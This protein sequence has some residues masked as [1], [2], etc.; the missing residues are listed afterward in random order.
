ML[1]IIILGLFIFVFYI[2][3]SQTNTTDSVVKSVLTTPSHIDNSKRPSMQPNDKI[4]Q[5]HRIDKVYRPETNVENKKNENQDCEEPVSTETSVALNHEKTS[6]ERIAQYKKMIIELKDEK[7]KLELKGENTSEIDRKI[8]KLQTLILRLSSDNKNISDKNSSFALNEHLANDKND[9][10]ITI[11]KSTKADPCASI[12]AM[13]LGVTYTG[14]LAASGSDWSTYTDCSYTESGDEGVYSFTPSSTGNYTFSGTATSGDPDFFLMSSCGNTGTNITGSCWDYGDRTVSLVAGTTYYLVVDN[15]SSSS[16]AEYSIIVNSAAAGPSNDDCTGAIT[17][18]VGA[19]CSFSSYTN[20]NATATSGVP[21]PGCAN[22]LGGD[23]WFKATVPASGHIILDMDDNVVTDAGMAIY[24]GTCGS[25]SL[26]ECDDDDSNNGL[27][28]MIDKSG[29]SSGTTI[30]IR[31][32]EYGNDNNGSFYICAY[33]PGIGACGSVTNIA[34]CGTSTTV[35]SGG[36]SGNWNNQECGSGTP[37]AE[38]I[39]SFTPTTTAAYYIVVTSA[40][41]Y[42]TYA[43]QTGTCQSTGWTCM[44]RPNAPG[45]FGPFNWTAGVTYYILVDDEDASSSTHTFYIKCPETPGTYYHPT[46]GLQGTYLGSCMVNTCTGTYTDDGGAANYS[47]NIN[48]IYRTFCPDATGKCIRAT[49]NSMDIEENGTSCY[50]YLIVRNGPTQGSP[51]LWAGCKTLASTNS[52]LG[53]FSNPFTA[54]NTSGCLTFQFYSDNTITRPGWNI[55]LS[56]VDCAASPTNNDCISATSICG[57]TNVNSASPGPGITSTCGGCNLSENY[58]NW[59]YF[60]ITNSGRL[61]LDIKPED[62]FE[63]YD[64]ALY[65]ASSC[66]NLGNPVRCTYAMTPQYCQPVSSGA[67][68]YISR[69]R[70]NTIDNTS[71]YYNDFY[72]NYTT[73]I[74]STVTAG[75]A[76]NLQVTVA[77][78]SMYVVAWF[79][80]NKN[81]QF[82]SGEYYSLGSGNNTT[83]STSI[84]VPVT[85]RPGKT[86]FRVYTTRSGAVPNT[87]ACISYANGEIEDYAIFISDGTHCSN[88]VKDADEIGVD[89]GGAGCVPCDASYWP[90]NTGMNSTSTDYS[91]DVTGDSWVQ[92]IPVNAGESYYLMVNNWSPGANGFDLIWNF[93]EGGAMDCSIVLPIELLDFNVK[94]IGQFTTLYWETASEINN[95]YFT[96]MK[97]TDAIIY[98]PIGT[99]KG[100]G[101]SNTIQRY[102]FNDNEPI[103]QTTYYRL[104]QIDFDGKVTYSEVRV[105]LPD[106]QSSVQQFN[107]FNDINNENLNI[108]LIGYPNTKLDYA[109]VDVMGR[110]IKQGKINIDENALGGLKLS[111][112]DIAA[113][114]YNIVISD[115]RYTVKKKFVIV[116]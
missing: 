112:N 108:T 64:M 32:W 103:T 92:G 80:W 113:G 17:L 73:S 53:T 18:T 57:A 104:K 24:T 95:D 105:V 100:A 55:S 116:K 23:V 111:T 54:S 96:I 40:S 67:S 106:L 58:S 76:Y 89:C 43:Y 4:E 62:F 75:S 20:A 65:Q 3:K 59:Y 21:A 99:I 36:G 1:K 110:I 51:I 8:E 68:Y 37:G 56:C 44:A 78:T 102:T 72:A 115:G 83:L 42:M 28:A 41:S 14:T 6:Q 29:L 107:V 87:D 94:L 79:D 11:E 31:V 47:L 84:T 66:A 2:S 16:S 101:N 49:F 22:Y 90:T 48:S 7:N 46:E 27:M 35:T 98:K 34:S 71:T 85:A 88:G 81:L 45:T 25:L 61:Y 70:F 5:I 9:F 74:S 39:F 33:D 109:I 52:L 13:T 15:Y 91:E 114:I 26:V 50:D 19:S 12:T 60:E 93:T 86:A 97:S 82:D 38:K 77:G 69:V 10:N 63:D 30:Y